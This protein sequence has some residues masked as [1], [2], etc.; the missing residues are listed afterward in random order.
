MGGRLWRA[1]APTLPVWG[2]GAFLGLLALGLW[3]LVVRELEPLGTPYVVPWMVL[4]LA[5]ALAETTAV[6]VQWFRRDTH[7]FSLSEIPIVVGMFVLSPGAL[8]AVGRRRILHR[9]D[10]AASVADEA[11]LQHGPVRPRR[12][13]RPSAVFYSVTSAEQRAGASR[14]HGRVPGHRRERRAQRWSASPRSSR[15]RSASPVTATCPPL[16]R[17]NLGANVINT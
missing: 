4:A 3:V 13:P 11:D 1:I 12:R 8:I 17:F 10:H 7:T 9:P 14:D 16:L 2:F 5:H 15:C 6:H